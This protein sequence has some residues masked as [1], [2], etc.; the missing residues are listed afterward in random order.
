MPGGAPISSSDAPGRRTALF[1][2]VAQ[3]GR[4][5]AEALAYAH[6]R[7]VIHRDIKPSNLILDTS[8]VVWITDFG[9]AKGDD[10][11]LTHTGDVIG[12]VRYM[13]PERFR[14]E[15]DARADI[16][17][18]GLTLYELL[19][20]EPAFHSSD[21]LRLMEKIKSQDPPRPR[22]ID[23]RIPR[24]LETIVLKSI[25]KEP[26]RRYATAGAMADDLRRFHEGEPIQ[27]R[28][29][30]SVERAVKWMRRRPYVAMSLGLVGVLGFFLL[31]VQVRSNIKIER[32]LEEAKFQQSKAEISER[33]AHSARTT[34]EEERAKAA[35][36]A[37][38]AR[39]EAARSTAR[40]AQAAAESGA[41]ERG[42]FKLVDALELA[43][44]ETPDDR[45]T[46]QALGRS[47][48]AWQT[49]H[50]VLRHLL[51]GVDDVQFVG[52]GGLTLV[53]FRKGQPSLIDLASG[54]NVDDPSL[55]E[56]RAPIQFA[57][58]DLSL[59]V[60]KDPK[61]G[62]TF[63]DRL[64]RRPRSV[65]PAFKT[66]IARDL[67]AQFGPAAVTSFSARRKQAGQSSGFIGSTRR[68]NRSALPAWC[69]SQDGRWIT[70]AACCRR[71]AGT[72]CWPSSRSKNRPPRGRH[73][74]SDSGTSTP[75]SRSAASGC[76]P[77]PR[78]GTGRSTA[79]A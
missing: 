46:R 79:R 42:L 47:L 58:P 25:E 19:T 70:T 71:L 57:S 26:E 54:R 44:N 51:D 48:A 4:Q 16:Y 12:T 50:P 43:P 55:R 1:R 8:G 24:D 6:A 32:A 72:R 5:V 37:L 73:D 21:R 78:G 29:V 23:T 27:A 64:T 41:I 56:L 60:S 76:R 52:D 77:E 22:A 28:A 11:G 7:G 35:A 3:I 31:L 61:T 68:Q 10:E 2:S 17:A 20:L 45:A 66:W 74:E 40:E 49:A 75:T 36:A 9:L 38:D 53:V 67:T 62:L 39:R 34:A 59:L 13:A 15:G 69:R 30:S 14:G 33:A 18:L 63:Y 65:L